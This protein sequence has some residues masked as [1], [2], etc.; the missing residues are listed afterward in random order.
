M[1]ATLPET[2]LRLD[3]GCGGNKR[4]GHI[5]ID[6][7]AAPGVDHVVD[8]MRERLPF[9][10]DSVDSVFSSHFLEHAEKPHLV[11]HEILRVCKPGAKVEIWTPYPR[12]SAAFLYSHVSYHSE[13]SWEHYCNLYPDYHFK[14][15]PGVLRLDGFQYVLTRDAEKWLAGIS[16]PVAIRYMFNVVFELKAE[17]TVLKGEEYLDK[18][19]YIASVKPP[20]C[21]HGRCREERRPFTSFPN[22]WKF[23]P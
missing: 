16:L 6:Y 8:L 19:A 1:L 5:G 7:V 13:L 9:A 17:L 21:V 2:A 15:L 14:G 11:L 22:F 12:H 10:D 18:T 20:V 23:D 3:I 4:A